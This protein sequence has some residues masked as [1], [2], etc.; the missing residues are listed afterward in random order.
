MSK[1][2]NFLV[3]E[4]KL[5]PQQTFEVIYYLQ[6]EL[7]VLPDHY[8]LC[9]ACEALYDTQHGGMFLDQDLVDEIWCEDELLPLPEQMDKFYCENCKP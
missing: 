9:S 6:E 5:T 8:E 1:F 7:E 2:F 4:Q 3:K